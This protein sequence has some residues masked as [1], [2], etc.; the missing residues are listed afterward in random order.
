MAFFFEQDREKVTHALFVIHD[1]YFT[2]I[3]SASFAH[4]AELFLIAA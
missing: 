3:N 1:K 4:S 2:H